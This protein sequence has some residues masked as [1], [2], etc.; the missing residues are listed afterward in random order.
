MYFYP[1]RTHEIAKA[2]E[3]KTLHK[4]NLTDNGRFFKGSY[5]FVT[6]NILQKLIPSL[7]KNTAFNLKCS[8]TKKD[9]SFSKQYFIL[10]V[11]GYTF[12]FGRFY[13]KFEKKLRIRILRILQNLIQKNSLNFQILK[14]TN[15][16]RGQNGLLRFHIPEH[17]HPGLLHHS[18]Q[19]RII[20]SPL[21]V[22][23][24]FTFKLEDITLVA[25]T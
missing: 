17:I 14:T 22:P 3:C 18:K 7:I 23:N 13:L 10:H 11:V 16:P 2:L 9:N 15:I 21:H 24:I 6:F 19:I 12:L 4:M 20:R 25:T 5:K 8:I 1:T